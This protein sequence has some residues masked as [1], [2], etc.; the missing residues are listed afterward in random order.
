MRQPLQ[1][2]RHTRIRATERYWMYVEVRRLAVLRDFDNQ[3]RKIGYLQPRYGN[4]NY[5]VRNFK[6]LSVTKPEPEPTQTFFLSL[7]IPTKHGSSFQVN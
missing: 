4:F 1:V 5:W 6:V 7:F 2:P 3:L